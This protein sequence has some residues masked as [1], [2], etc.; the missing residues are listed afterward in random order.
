MT[1]LLDGAVPA[2]PDCLIATSLPQWLISAEAKLRDAYFASSRLSLD[3]SAVAMAIAQGF[4]SPEAF[5]RPLLQAALDQKFGS[6]R[7]N[8]DGHELIRM[9]PLADGYLQPR[10]QTLLQAAMQNFEPDEALPGGIEPHS[11]ILPIGKLRT[12]T[13]GAGNTRWVHDKADEVALAPEAFAALARG[14]DLGGQYQRHFREVFQPLSTVLPSTHK[15]QS[16]IAINITLALRDALEVQAVAARIKHDI[17]ESAYDMLRSI[18]QPESA[19]QV[20]NWAGKAVRISQ[21]RLLHSRWHPGWS[22]QGMLM[23]E[24]VEGSGP[25]L[26]YRPG[27]PVH[28]LKQYPSAQAFA[29]ALREQLRS[30]AYV[31]YVQGFITHRSHDAF[32]ARLSETLAPTPVPWPGQFEQPPIADPEAD[33]G[34]AREPYNGGLP[35]LMYNQYLTLIGENARSFVV[36]VAD[37]NDTARQERLAWWEGA[38]LSSLNVLAFVPVVGEFIAAVGAISMVKEVCMGV[39]DWQHG[40]RQSALGHFAGVAENLALLAAGVAGGAAFA[41][42]PFLEQME[43]VTHADSQHLLHPEL[44][45]YDANL[46][47]PPDAAVNAHGQYQVQGEH[48][49]RIDGRLFRQAYDTQLQD[50]VIV[51]PRDPSAYRP[52][53]RHNGEGG[54]QH[55]H[56]QPLS[57]H[58]ID[59]LRASGAPAEGLNDAQL[60]M[61]LSANGI[62]EALLRACHVQH[63]P[64]PPLLQAS[65]QRVRAHADID[66]LMRHLRARKPLGQGAEYSLPL[67]LRVPGWPQDLGVLAVDA[68]GASIRYGGERPRTVQVS[69]HALLSGTVGDRVVMQLSAADKRQMFADDV[70]NTAAAQATDLS[71]SLAEQVAS[72]RNEMSQAMCERQQVDLVATAKPI[73]AVFPTLP[74]REANRIAAGASAAEARQLI[75]LGKVPVRMAEEAVMALREQRLTMA[76]EG[77]A[78][79]DLY[80]DDRDA[81]ALALLAQ[82]PGWT[83]RI[84]IEVRDGG[85]AG[86]LVGQVGSAT[87]E[88]KRIVRRTGT[89]QAYDARE[90][91]LS[92]AQDL[93][94][95]LCSSLPDS[96]IRALN[97]PRHGGEVLRERLASA[98][99]A[100]RQRAARLLG[101][102]RVQPWFR[103]PLRDSQGLGYPL[104]GRVRPNW[105]Q[106]TRLRRLYPSRTDAQ[107]SALMGELMRSGETVELALQRCEQ[108]YRALYEALLDWQ[109]QGM[110]VAMRRRA[111]ARIIS[112]WRRET[113]TLD[114]TT[115]IPGTLPVITA[116]FP[117]VAVLYLRGLSAGT[118]LSLFLSRFPNVEVLNLQSC[119]LTRIPAQVGSLPRL[120]RLDLSDNLLLPSDDMFAP[121]IQGEESATLSTLVMKQAFALPPVEQPLVAI[122][123]TGLMVEPLTRLKRLKLLDFSSH[124]FSFSDQ[125]LGIIGSLTR[126]RTLRLSDCFLQLGGARASAFSR[127]TGLQTLDLSGSL[128]GL[129]SIDVSPFTRLVNLSLHQ[130]RLSDWPVG[131]TS[132]LNARPVQLRVV[133]LNE[134]RLVDLPDLAGLEFFTAR[135]TYLEGP[136]YLNMDFNP[137]NRSS[138]RRIRA[139]GMGFRALRERPVPNQ[140]APVWLDGCPEPLRERIDADRLSDDAAAFY[141]V[142]DQTGRTGSYLAHPQA[143]SARMWE[144]MRALLPEPG[145]AEADLLGVSD[146]RQEL[147]ERATL[148]ENTCGDGIGLALDDFE[149]RVLA[150]KAASTAAQGGEAMFVPLIEL[151]RQLHKTALVDEYAVALTQGRIDRREA[152]L[153]GDPAPELQGFDSIDEERLIETSPDEVEIR[154]ML[155]TRLQSRLGLREQ[156]VRLYSEFVSPQTVEQVGTAVLARATSSSLVDWVVDQPFWEV[157]LRKVYTSRF[158]TLEELWAMV[159]SHFEDAVDPHALVGT[160][161][162]RLPEVLATLAELDRQ[163][164]WSNERGEAQKVTLDD[165]GSLRMYNAINHGRQLAQAALVLTLTK[166]VMGVR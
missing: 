43:R 163:V 115:L 14:L 138:V 57:W 18:L 143:F 98:A 154:L 10:H 4:Q 71:Q 92:G 33:I 58:G 90:Q 101:Q 24:T 158:T 65:M 22:L 60:T 126:L 52:I 123:L 152:L 156:P 144:V 47:L 106:R 23:L 7:L 165:Q 29:E 53:V 85:W 39:E 27:E 107:L 83:D 116:Q 49:V 133:T 69:Q 51:H 1:D 26:V 5:C 63:L 48:H 128:N 28:P 12:R 72:H 164:A 31:A 127:L 117:R 119:R 129:G 93:F 113:L 91:E 146:L 145:G 105:D 121:L 130:C 50:W 38:A 44:P 75:T 114:L 56:Q 89:Y 102:R 42:S 79:S 3:S 34:L 76:C 95:T 151:A 100:D 81:L 21:L 155:R 142:M 40:Q 68:Q 132:L 25:C 46:P 17:D 104:S 109:R 80:S 125:A 134:N 140:D 35:R 13:E 94:S 20:P 6:L 67:L 141:R 37:R 54:W 157:Y 111:S 41:R 30:P 160:D 78:R 88:L 108:E 97:L 36:P 15:Q 147:F 87:G 8:V 86:N 159:M 9:Q 84:R 82:L 135:R 137:L 2:L 55:V 62:D 166:Q 64:L 32:A 161:S 59:L 153:A 16:D 118:D 131:L 112:A 149:T 110:G 120:R 77:L 19:G 139:A 148:I 99:A 122:E 96:E 136:I 73:H 124:C 162:T 74:T 66:R 11:L 70:E 61:I 150:W 103:T 45:G